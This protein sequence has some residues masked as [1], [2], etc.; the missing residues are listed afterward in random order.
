MNR[1]SDEVMLNELFPAALC[2]KDQL[3]D[4]TNRAVAAGRIRDVVRV[5]AS[6][7]QQ[8]P[9]PRLPDLIA[10]SVECR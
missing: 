2:F 7:E 1:G 4:F 5:F 8:R 3:D 6:F 10:A 9:Q